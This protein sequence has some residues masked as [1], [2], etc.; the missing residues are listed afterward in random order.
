MPRSARG[1]HDGINPPGESPD[2]RW[3]PPQALLCGS[4][5]QAYGATRRSS[6]ASVLLFTSAAFGVTSALNRPPHRR[7]AYR[8]SYWPSYNFIGEHYYK[9]KIWL[10]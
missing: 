4:V 9:D 10:K 5:P 8:L 2:D 7:D 1:W 3:P 6:G